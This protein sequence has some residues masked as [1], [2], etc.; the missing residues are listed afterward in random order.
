MVSDCSIEPGESVLV[1]LAAANRDP[2]V[3]PDPAEFRPG[4]PAPALFTFGAAGHGCPGESLALGI[5]TAVLDA[6]LDAGWQPA[7]AR[8][9]SVAYRPSGNIRVPLL[10]GSAVAFSNLGDSG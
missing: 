10:T 3:N 9:L 2:A 6:I 8:P 1:L 7:E 4:R 5:A